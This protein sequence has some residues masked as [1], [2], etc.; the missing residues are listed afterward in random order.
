[1]KY[2]YRNLEK[3]DIY[4]DEMRGNKQMND[5]VTP[6]APGAR[7]FGTVVI[8]IEESALDLDEIFQICT[9]YDKTERSDIS[10]EE[11]Y[12]SHLNR[13]TF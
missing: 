8:G 4:M 1:M 13:K 2:Q 9:D 11:I 7:I 6:F 10:Y 12:R 3:Y 5:L